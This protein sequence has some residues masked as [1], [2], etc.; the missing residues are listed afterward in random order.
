MIQNQ[1]GQIAARNSTATIR[2]RPRVVD[3]GG[4]GCP[5]GTITSRSG[6]CRFAAEGRDV[7]WRYSKSADSTSA[8]RFGQRR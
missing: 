1:K 8:C 4:S 3:R 7:I 6:T 5:N 2:T